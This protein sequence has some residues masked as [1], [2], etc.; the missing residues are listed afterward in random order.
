MGGTN[1]FKRKKVL[2][3]Q[4]E[5]V[6]QEETEMRENIS[7]LD[8]ITQGNENQGLEK[9]KTRKLNFKKKKA[10]EEKVDKKKVEKKNPNNK[11]FQFSIA[12]IKKSSYSTFKKMNRAIEKINPNGKGIQLFYKLI[13]AFTIPFHRQQRSLQRSLH[14]AKHPMM[15]FKKKR[16]LLLLK[17][18]R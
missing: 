17:T 14:L 1:M 6:M 7:D 5:S 10:N 15:I 8:S 4:Q 16:V 18:Q 2:E 3:Q 13:I 12:A 9:D 11:G